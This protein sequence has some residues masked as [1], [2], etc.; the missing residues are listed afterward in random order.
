[1]K[2]FLCMIRSGNRIYIVRKKGQRPQQ[3]YPSLHT[4]R[5]CA[6]RDQ[7]FGWDLISFFAVS[8]SYHSLDVRVG[9]RALSLAGFGLI[10]V[11]LSI[12]LVGF[13][14]TRGDRL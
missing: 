2:V 10:Y 6:V 1:M 3:K 8:A 5:F 13:A 12:P 9:M 11:P 14:T 7:S 4:V